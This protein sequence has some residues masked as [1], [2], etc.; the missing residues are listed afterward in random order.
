MRSNSVIIA[1][2]LE[3]LD[4]IFIDTGRLTRR[5]SLRVKAIDRI[6]RPI[7]PVSFLRM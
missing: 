1:L 3:K 6:P 5:P 2:L 7:E 4:S